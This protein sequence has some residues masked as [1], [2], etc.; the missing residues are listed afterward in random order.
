VILVT[1]PTS[2]IGGDTV[3]LTGPRP[4]SVAASTATLFT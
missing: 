1:A 3:G 2:T 4:V